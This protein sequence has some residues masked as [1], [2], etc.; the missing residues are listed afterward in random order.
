MNFSSKEKK[1]HKASK[2]RA[3]QADYEAYTKEGASVKTWSA[4]HK[5]DYGAKPIEPLIQD[6]PG[7][8][9]GK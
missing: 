9:P 5:P 4:T 3:K 8:Y 1:I 6:K 2:E 7:N